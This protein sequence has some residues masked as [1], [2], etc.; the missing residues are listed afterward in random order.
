MEIKLVD[1]NITDGD[2]IV[3]DNLNLD[4]PCNK[5]I[6]LYGDK[7]QSFVDLLLNKDVD[8]GHIIDNSY[9]ESISV[10]DDYEHFITSVVAD[11]FYLN[12]DYQK[13]EKE[14]IKIIDKFD[15]DSN[16]IN[17][18]TATLST[19]E[20]KLVKLIIAMFSK[21][22][23]I[24]VY[25]LFN[26][27]DFRNKKLFSNIVKVIKRKYSKNIFIHDYDMDMINNLVDRLLIVDNNLI[28][29]GKMEDIYNHE[30]INQVDIDCPNFI[31]LKRMLLEKGIDVSKFN[32]INDLVKEVSK[33]V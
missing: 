17:R 33:D 8:N 18:N 26:G 20:K 15:L 29:I 14:I 30:D 10:F 23:T 32:N 25:D 28:I 22:K 21:S 3:F 2:N 24:I 9:L 19:C 5:I 1:I 7:Y 11:E 27:L 31:K 12:F 6:G 13:V 16:F 4:I